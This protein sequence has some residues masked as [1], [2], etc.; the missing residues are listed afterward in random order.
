MSVV[1]LSTRGR[2]KPAQTLFE[3]GTGGL[4]I[5]GWSHKGQ[6]GFVDF[7]QSWDQL[8]SSSVTGGGI[9]AQVANSYRL[10]SRVSI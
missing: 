7:I 9:V 5:G 2:H 10:I 6:L 8:E 1:T 4:L 3:S